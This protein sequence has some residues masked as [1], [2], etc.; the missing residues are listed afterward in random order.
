MFFVISGLD[1]LLNDKG[2]PILLEINA[3]PSLSLSAAPTH[4]DSGGGGGGEEGEV[5][6]KVDEDIKKPIVLESLLLACPQYQI[7]PTW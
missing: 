3:S 5:F 7:L 2:D 4:S 6:S 1:F